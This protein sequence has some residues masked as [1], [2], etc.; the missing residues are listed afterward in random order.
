[1]IDFIS[2]NFPGDAVSKPARICVP[3]TIP[4]AGSAAAGEAPTARRTAI[5]AEQPIE[6]FRNPIR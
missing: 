1:V 4:T 5:R 3:S 6:R 2:V